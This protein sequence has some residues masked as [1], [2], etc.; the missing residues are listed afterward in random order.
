MMT[1]HKH[2]STVFVKTSS[3]STLHWSLTQWC[4]LF[5]QPFCKILPELTILIHHF[6]KLFVR[7]KLRSLSCCHLSVDIAETSI[8]RNGG[9]VH[10]VHSGK[11][12]GRS[13]F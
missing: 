13:P 11:K 12:V 10:L 1:W 8:L 5:V 4:V 9:L 3:L 7:E 2:R 6:F